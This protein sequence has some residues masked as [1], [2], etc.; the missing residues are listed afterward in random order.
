MTEWYLA[1]AKRHADDI[2]ARNPIRQRLQTLQTAKERATD[3]RGRLRDQ[4]RTFP[5]SRL[6]GFLPEEPTLLSFPIPAREGA[7]SVQFDDKLTRVP[8]WSIAEMISACD[9]LGDCLFSQWGTRCHG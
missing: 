8:A 9:E 3:Q 6:L 5:A 7:R 1:Q 4:L 2:S